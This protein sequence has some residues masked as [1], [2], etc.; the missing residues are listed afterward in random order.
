[1]SIAFAV[2]ASAIGLS[3]LVKSGAEYNADCTGAASA[4]SD[5][6]TVGNATSKADKAETVYIIAAADGSAQKVIVTDWIKNIASADKINDKTLLKNIEAVKGDS[7]YTISGDEKIWDAKSGDIYYKGTID[8]ALPVDVILTYT[9]GGKTISASELAGKSGRVTL[10]FDFKNNQYETVEINGKDEK[11]FV[12]FAVLTGLV[13]DNDKFTNIEIT[14][15]KIIN[16]GNRNIAVGYALPGAQESLSLGRDIID[17]PDYIEISADTTGFELPA[18]LTLVT[19]ELWNGFDVSK[20]DNADSLKDKLSELDSGAFALVNGTSELYDN[21][22]K[23]A[24]KLPD[25]V[26][27]IISGVK[28]LDE[29]AEKIGDNMKTLTG[30]LSDLQT[31]LKRISGNSAALNTGAKQV[32]ESLLATAD[33]ALSGAS[34]TVPKLTIDN[35]SKTLDGVAAS[36][37]EENIRANAKA[38]AIELVTAQ[39]NVKKDDIRVQIKAGYRNQI[40]EGVLKAVGMNYTADQYDTMAAQ[41]YVDTVT[42]A[43][44]SSAVDAQLD[45]MTDQ[46]IQ[47]LID[48]N[49]KSDSVI[50][51]IEEAVAKAAAGKSQIES[52]KAQ[53]DSYKTFYAGL[54]DYTSGVDKAYEGSK[55]LYSGSKKL[56]EGMDELKNGLDEFGD[57]AAALSDGDQSLTAGVSKL[58]DGAKKIAEGTQKFYSDGISKLTSLVGEDAANALIRFRAMLDVSGDYN[59]FGGISDGMNGTVKFIYRTAAVDSGN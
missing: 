20:L 18:T 52:L 12:P 21:M 30:G 53:L 6:S 24:D 48:Q 5:A 37:S 45:T 23:L 14:N 7:S 46:Q 59:T 40:L 8:K 32:F 31:G 57:K 39:V 10:R 25:I 35:Y 19:N 4:V 17:I 27:D 1:M 56:S 36:I 3:S 41:G 28:T 38:K 55:S 9:L 34:I 44:I 16:D 11:I 42:Q 2:S 26:D 50:S 29:G 54:S 51:Q 49:M 22:Q 47:K 15:G 58:A 33:S 13:L 43:K